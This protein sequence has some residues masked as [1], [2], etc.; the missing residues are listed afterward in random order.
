MNILKPL[1]SARKSSQ[2][3]DGLKKLSIVCVAIIALEQCR[4]L[5]NSY[6]F[7]S[8]GKQKGMN[9]R[10]PYVFFKFNNRGLPFLNI[11]SQK[12]VCCDHFFQSIA[13]I[14][15]SYEEI[16]FTNNTI[17]CSKQSQYFINSYL[18]QFYR[19]YVVT[20]PPFEGLHILNK[21]TP[22][23]EIIMIHIHVPR[24]LIHICV[25]L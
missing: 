6:L 22:A 20:T 4:Y 16:S 8:S 1:I 7:Q 19:K 24:E 15:I 12:K 2:N 23:C 17:H 25:Y 18:F 11:Q 5:I 9:S 13:N 10:I 21:T 3:G 14:P